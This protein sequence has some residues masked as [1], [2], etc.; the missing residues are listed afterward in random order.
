MVHRHGTNW[1]LCL[2][3]VAAHT[4]LHRARLPGTNGE[5]ER[6]NH[7]LI[8]E[9]THPGAW[10]SRSSRSRVLGMFLVHYIHPSTWPTPPSAA[11]RQL[12][13]LSPEGHVSNRS[14]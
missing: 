8:N 10:T 7:A 5:A 12:G 1:G 6:F 11:T 4:P 9:W 13:G 3:R 14:T 2:H